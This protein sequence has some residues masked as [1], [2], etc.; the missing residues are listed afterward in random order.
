MNNHVIVICGPTASGKTSLG[1][2]IAKRINGEI[3]SADSMQLYKYMNVGTAK[4]TEEEKEGIPHHML[5]ICTPDEEYNVSRYKEDATKCIEDIISRGKTPIIVGGTGLYIDTLVRGIEFNEIEN[6]IEYR[7]QLEEMVKENGIDFL[8]EE[9]T[10]VDPESAKQIDKNNVRR[11]IRALEIYKVTGRKKSDLDK[12]SVKGSKYNF[13]VYGILWDREILYNRIN[14]RVDIMLNTGLVEEVKELREKYNLSKT[15]LQGIGYK[16]VIKYLDNEYSY[17]DMVNAIKQESRRY[18][19]RQMTWFNHMDY[20]E[21]L[22]G[23]DKEKMIETILK[24]E[25][26]ISSK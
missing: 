20:V 8:F 3:I 13:Q 14:E 26:A 23:N 16:E 18:A 22:D 1:I 24:M 2:E 15:A 17:E 7:N 19:K 5:D 21:W 12:E 10:K 11:V 25:E 4:P 9:L 6:D